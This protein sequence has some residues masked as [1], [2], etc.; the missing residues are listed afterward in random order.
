[1]LLQTPNIGCLFPRRPTLADPQTLTAA[2]LDYQTEE[3][4]V[5]AH[6]T[7]RPTPI[8]LHWRKLRPLRLAVER[9]VARK[10]F[11]R[12][13]MRRRAELR[14][15][16]QAAIEQAVDLVY[17]GVDQLDPRIV[18]AD[19]ER[20]AELLRLA[21][22]G[23]RWFGLRFEQVFGIPVDPRVSCHVLHQPISA[24]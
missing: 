23:N 21:R 1:M 24:T 3:R 10:S 11:A 16:I 22:L 8:I 13:A 2:L 15:A 4:D 6:Q 7:L 19:E 20:T 14:Q 12:T 9:L 5:F 18:H 17:L